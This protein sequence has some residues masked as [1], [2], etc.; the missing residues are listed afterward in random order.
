MTNHPGYD[1]KRPKE[2]FDKYGSHVLM[3]MYMVKYGASSSGFVVPPLLQS[4]IGTEIEQG[5]ERTS[6]AKETIGH[7]VDDTI[8]YLEDMT[9]PFDN[10]TNVASQW[11]IRPTEL[12]ELKSYLEIGEDKHF[13]GGLHQ[14]TTHEGHYSWVSGAHHPKQVLRH[15][16]NVVNNI[17]GSNT[18]EKEKIDIKIA[19]D[20]VS[21]QLYDAISKVCWIDITNSTLT[22]DCGRFSLAVGVFENA[23]F[24]VVA[25]ENLHDLTAD[26]IKLFEQCNTNY[27]TIR[28]TQGKQTKVDWSTFCTEPPNSRNFELDVMA[29]AQL[30]SS[31]WSYQQKR[32]PFEREGSLNYALLRW[33]RKD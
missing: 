24:L 18:E 5:Q 9:H 20:K 10:D 23:Q 31:S 12:A 16:K 15:L 19:P 14:L 26:D 3:M 27:L 8:A 33:G 6:F 28:R 21:K 1:I 22:V 13:P 11:S 7:L 2:F 17:D 4:C 30:L 25:M 32:T 29:I